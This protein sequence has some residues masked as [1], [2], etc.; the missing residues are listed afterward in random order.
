VHCAASAIAATQVRAT[1]TPVLQRRSHVQTRKMLHTS[2][3]LLYTCHH[4]YDRQHITN[5][6]KKASAAVSS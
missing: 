5:T 2:L 1:A 3:Q 4:Y 6:N